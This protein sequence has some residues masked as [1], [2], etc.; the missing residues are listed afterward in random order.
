MITEDPTPAGTGTHITAFRQLGQLGSLHPKSHVTF[1][2]LR[3]VSCLLLKS[4]QSIP[5]LLEAVF[6]FKGN[7]Y[8]TWS[9]L[10]LLPYRVLGYVTQNLPLFVKCERQCLYRAKKE[11]H[12]CK[13]QTSLKEDK[14]P[15][16]ELEDGLIDIYVHTAFTLHRVARVSGHLTFQ[17]F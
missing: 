17:T 6:Q 12:N 16:F 13:N 8:T 2:F 5:I 1:N 3:L 4:Y 7:T 10:L 11:I 14:A 9:L 15:H